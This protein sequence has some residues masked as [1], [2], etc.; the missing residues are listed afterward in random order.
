[1][2]ERTV[3]VVWPFAS[4][5]AAGCVIV[6]SVA[7]RL[8]VLPATGLLFASRSVTVIVEAAPPSAA[9][10]AGLAVTV[11]VVADTAPAVNVTDAVCVTVIVSVVSVAVSVAVPAV[12]ERTVPVVWPLASVA[13]AGCVSVS[14]APREEASVT[15]LPLTGL[16]LASRS[17]TVI[18]DVA[19]PSAATVAGLAVTVDIV[20]DTAPAVNVTDTVCVT[21]IASVVSV[22]VIVLVPA[23]V[24]RIVPVVCPFASVAAAGCVTVPSVAA[25]LTVLPLTGFPFA[26]RNVTV[27]IA[28]ARPSAV[29]VVGLAVTVEVVADTPPAVKVT[30]TVCVTV[31]VSV[32][33]VAVIVLVP[34]IVEAIVPVV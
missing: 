18:V 16:P 31:I 4:V 5:A 34:A 21:V 1:V 27:I 25:R 13:A 33:S 17:V 7:A 9:T 22:A 6:P 24:D 8:T 14:A 10:V 32:T 19:T 29:T 3:P 15:V 20:A 11:D 12:V 23:V 2:V 26:S 30:V 28:V